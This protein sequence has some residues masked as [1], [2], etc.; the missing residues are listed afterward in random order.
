MRFA[1]FIDA[2]IKS[3]WRAELDAQHTGVYKLWK[4]MFPVIAELE[5]EIRGEQR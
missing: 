1:D 4:K 2:L 5:D 3:G